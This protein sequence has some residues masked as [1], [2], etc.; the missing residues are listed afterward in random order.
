MARLKMAA[1][2]R[3]PAKD[4][5]VPSKRPG[6]GSYPIE[7]PSHARDALARASGKPVQAKVDA[8]V[9]RKYPSM[10][11][12]KGRGGGGSAARGEVRHPQSHE[13]F[14][15]LGSDED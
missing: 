9:H 5:A 11:K 6:S 10:G 7:N 1:R 13:E 8:A 12:R 14:M 15:R 2:K 4:F 3:L